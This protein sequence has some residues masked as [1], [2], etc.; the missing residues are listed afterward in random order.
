MTKSNFRRFHTRTEVAEFFSVTRI[1]IYR[2][3][4][5]LK[6]PQRNSWQGCH[7]QWLSEEDLKEWFKKMRAIEVKAMFK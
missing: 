3:E 6:L 7:I 5:F 1:T 2:W 4:K